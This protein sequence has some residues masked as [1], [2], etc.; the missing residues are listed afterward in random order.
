MD[1][2]LNDKYDPDRWMALGKDLRDFRT[3]GPE[4]DQFYEAHPEL[5]QYVKRWWS[6]VVE[7]S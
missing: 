5:R 1:D 6:M 4:A 2:D 3:G 7:V